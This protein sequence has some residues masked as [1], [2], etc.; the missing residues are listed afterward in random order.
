M[1]TPMKWE[2]SAYEVRTTNDRRKNVIGNGAI[3]PIVLPPGLKDHGDL[4]WE[5][6]GVTLEVER[7]ELNT[8]YTER[9]YF[10]RPIA[11]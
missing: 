2:Y 10:K 11:D 7:A 6:T 4:E 5:L 8:Y 9:F 1:I 3:N